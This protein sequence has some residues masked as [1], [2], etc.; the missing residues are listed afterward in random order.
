MVD[1]Y[2]QGRAYIILW[3]VVVSEGV[4]WSMI[5]PESVLWRMIISEGVLSMV[6]STGVLW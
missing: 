4:L 2:F 5:V 6:V 3:S 1:G